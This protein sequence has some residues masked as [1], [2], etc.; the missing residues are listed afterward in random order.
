MD[1]DWDR[2]KCVV[3]SV[4]NNVSDTWLSRE[5]ETTESEGNRDREGKT[6][7]YSI[8]VDQQTDV[9]HMQR[10][11]DMKAKYLVSSD[12]PVSYTLFL[13]SILQIW[14]TF[15]GEC[16]WSQCF[17]QRQ[18]FLSEGS[19]MFSQCRQKIAFRTPRVVRFKNQDSSSKVYVVLS[20][21]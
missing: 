13:Y 21:Y 8:I 10:E 20:K 17:V 1:R 11:W 14:I 2:F 12:D 15:G 9:L 18:H 3:S 5:R 4:I 7:E 6:E 16:I 19:V